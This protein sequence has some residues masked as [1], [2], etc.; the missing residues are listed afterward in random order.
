MR[1]DWKETEMGSDL[2]YDE[3][4]R[5][6]V[7]TMTNKELVEHLKRMVETLRHKPHSVRWENWVDALDEEVMRE[8]SI[9]FG[10]HGMWGHLWRIVVLTYKIKR[11]EFGLWM[12]RKT[13]R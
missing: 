13:S 7:K 8:V 12:M 3:E 11:E 4:M 6:I 1:Q 5:Q 10:D 9:R 2:P